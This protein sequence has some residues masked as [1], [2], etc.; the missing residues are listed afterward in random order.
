MS[1]RLDVI[2]HAVYQAITGASD[3]SGV[4]GLVQ[5]S[6]TLTSVERLA[7]YQRS[8]LARLLECFESMFPALH[9]ALGNDLFRHFALDYLQRHPPI[10]YTLA[11]MADAFPRHLSETRPKGEAWPAFVVDLATLE[12][13]LLHVADGPGVEGRL[14][15]PAPDVT[16]MPVEE[17]L[18]LRPAPVPC[19]R[20]LGF[21]YPVH[22]YRIAARGGERPAIPGPEKCFVVLTRH[23]YRV[24]TYAVAEP[25]WALARLLDGECT[26]ADAVHRLSFR[27][28]LEEVR[29]WL[30][31]LYAKEWYG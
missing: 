1:E 9:A 18:A 29:G 28:T 27:P 24:M 11:K 19:L 14:R 16:A 31:D 13:A 25:Q 23:Q 12:L 8:Y 22:R 30:Q 4:A 10:S 2:Q 6:A 15:L 17:L 26:V 7:I 20:S 21:E 3:A 5:P